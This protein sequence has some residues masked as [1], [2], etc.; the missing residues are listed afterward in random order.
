M[1][2]S[3][4]HSDECSGS[5]DMELVSYSSRVFVCDLPD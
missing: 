1:A 5:G 4:E 2:S 3:C